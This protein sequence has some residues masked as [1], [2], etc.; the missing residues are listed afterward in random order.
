MPPRDTQSSSSSDPF[1]TWLFGF[2]GA[3]FG[4][5]LLPRAIKFLVRKLI[6]ETLSEIVAIVIA[7]LLAEKAVEFI[8]QHDD[9]PPQET[10]ESA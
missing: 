5:M 7:G 4:F 1:V 9:A 8:S 6:L 3:F 10:K 2:L